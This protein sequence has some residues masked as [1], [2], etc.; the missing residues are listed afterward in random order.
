[1]GSVF[2]NVEGFQVQK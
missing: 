1:L 2:V